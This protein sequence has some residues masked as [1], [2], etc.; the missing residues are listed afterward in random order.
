M[1]INKNV[2][3]NELKNIEE[4]NKYMSDIE[5]G[6]MDNNLFGHIGAEQIFSKNYVLQSPD[7]IIENRLGVCWDLVELERLFCEN[8]KLNFETYFIVYYDDDKCP[9]HTFLIYELDNKWYWF[10]NSWEKYRGIHQFSDKQ[11]LL[12][13]VRNKFIQDLPD[14]KLNYINLVLYKYDKPKYG[15]SVIEFYHHC[16]NGI[17]TK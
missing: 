15:I 2:A 9:T 6:W 10:E 12:E 5:Y 1:K 16:E 7:Q 4:L 11:E 17:I 14:E 3:F 8:N 13:D